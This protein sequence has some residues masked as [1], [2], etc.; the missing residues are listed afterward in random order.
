MG[1][2][3][4]VDFTCNFNCPVIPG[5]G[6][7]EAFCCKFCRT[8]RRSWLSKK[9]E[10][11]WTDDKGFLGENGCKLE[12]EDMPPE[13]RQYDCRKKAFYLCQVHFGYVTWDGEKWAHSELKRDMMVGGLNEEAISLISK[14]VEKRLGN[15]SR[16]IIRT[17]HTDEKRR[18]EDRGRR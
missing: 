15:Y 3:C 10:H 11:L 7:L 18:K 8:S 6:V 16:E 2:G 17:T 13:C 9:N 14:E 1:K 4:M 5:L 12:R